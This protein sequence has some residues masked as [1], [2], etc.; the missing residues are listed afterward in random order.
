MPA[1]EPSKPAIETL[2]VRQIEQRAFQKVQAA[3]QTYGRGTGGKQQ[4][5]YCS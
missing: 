5:L 1:A 2:C 3:M 4:D